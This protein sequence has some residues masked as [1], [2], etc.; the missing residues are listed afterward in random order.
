[1]TCKSEEILETPEGPIYIQDAIGGLGLQFGYRSDAT[2]VKDEKK[3]R[4]WTRYFQD[5]GRNLTLVRQPI[6]GKMVRAG[7]PNALR[8]EVWEMCS[9]SIYLRFA[10]KGVYQQI[11][12]SHKDVDSFVKDEIEKDLHRSLPEYEAYQTSEGISRLRRVLTAYSWKNTELGYCQAM[13][14][15]TSSLLIY[16]TEEQAFWALNSLVDHLCPGYYSS[17]MYGVLLDQVVLEEL[18]KKYM[19]KLTEHFQERQIQL[20]VACLPW[21]LTLYINSM[22][23]P[24]AFRILDCFFLEGSKILFQ[25]ALAIL[26]INEKELLTVDDDSELLVIAKEFFKAL[27]M[28]M[29]DTAT[30]QH[31]TKPSDIFNNLMKSAYTDFNKVTSD[32]I[33]E[34]RR[35]NEL[36][37]IGG[38]ETFTKRNALRNVKNTVYFSNDEISI[39]YDYFSS[40]LYYANN[41]GKSIVPEM[42]LKAFT[43]MLESM[44]TWAKFN[45]QNSNN[46]SSVIAGNSSDSMRIAQA[47][48][49]S[50]IRRL[51]ENFRAEGRTGIALVDTVT[52]L[53]EILRGDIMSKAAFFF[54]LYDKDKKDILT[55]QELYSMASEFHLILCLLEIPHPLDTIANFICLSAEQTNTPKAMEHLHQQLDV[56]DR[57]DIGSESGELDMKRVFEFT[58]DFHQVLMGTEA[59]MIEITLPMF[60]MIVLTEESLDQFIQ[61]DFPQS[62]KLQKSLVERQ[63]GLGHEI[64]EA[65]LVEG[66]KFASNMTAAGQQDKLSVSNTKNRSMLTCS[67]SPKSVKSTVSNFEDDDYEL[68]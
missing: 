28:P 66:K 4:I 37:V 2:E 43:K 65:L 62:F 8:G 13:N 56:F 51:F 21:F 46:T 26:K 12:D 53:G 54:A 22:P 55:N 42:D 47:I 20:S 16:M 9:G 57:D 32:Q 38:V 23:L 14:I 5:N 31:H 40:A 39:I 7:L 18:V 27:N 49:Q 59:P 6:F 30:E 3:L 68:I 48:L 63:K 25:I 29:D 41:Q 64:F 33:T 10:N 36:R 24:F 35:Q 11:L 61:T 52:K 15:V 45:N 58:N 19:P 50:F 67:R 17:S 44:T 1:M 60:R 34:L